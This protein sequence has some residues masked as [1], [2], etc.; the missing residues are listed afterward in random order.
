MYMSYTYTFAYA[1]IAKEVVV[2]V[3]EASTVT[4]RLLLFFNFP[5]KIIQC[6][7]VLKH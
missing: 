1:Y 4:I 5:K 6:E 3:R 2:C 7:H